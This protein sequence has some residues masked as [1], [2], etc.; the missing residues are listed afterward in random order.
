M[1]ST[2][3]IGQST[4]VSSGTQNLGQ[5]NSN[6]KEMRRPST[7]SR[8]RDKKVQSFLWDHYS[9]LTQHNSRITWDLLDALIG[10][11]NFK[12]EHHYLFI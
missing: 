9:H 2:A 3:K 10:S 8:R 12:I 4:K 1:Q 11:L 5:R 6:F 7:P